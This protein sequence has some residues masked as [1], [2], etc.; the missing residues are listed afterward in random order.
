MRHPFS[1]RDLYRQSEAVHE[2]ADTLWRKNIDK[3]ACYICGSKDCLR[4]FADIKHKHV[5]M[6]EDLKAESL[7]A[8][9]Y[10]VYRNIKVKSGEVDI[11]VNGKQ[12]MNSVQS[13]Q[14]TGLS[15]TSDHMCDRCRDS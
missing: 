5:G 6:V 8:R 14:C 13:S 11:M 12:A 1:S 2:S 7:K 9:Q 4:S 15:F 10:I 3:E